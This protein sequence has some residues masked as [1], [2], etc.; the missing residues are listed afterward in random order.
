MQVSTFLGTIASKF[1]AFPALVVV[2]NSTI[3][4]WVREFER[5]APVLR[6]VPFYGEKASR[7]VIKQFELYHKK[8]SRGYTNA[9]FHVMVTTYEAVVHPKDFGAVFK[10]QPRWEVLV[11][12]EGQRCKWPCLWETR[13]RELTRP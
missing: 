6:V 7:D 1:K 9:K 8:P 4:N 2:P 10:K 12:D 13:K 11:V 5:W 3:T